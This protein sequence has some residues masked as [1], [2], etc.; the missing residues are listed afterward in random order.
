M[1]A[2]SRVRRGVVR[3]E[4][5]VSV[6]RRASEIVELLAE[7]SADGAVLTLASGR[8]VVLPA[9][10]LDVLRASARELASGHDVSVVPSDSMLTPAEAAGLLGLSRPFVVRLLDD[11]TIPSE[12]LTNSR[13]RRVLLADVLAFAARRERRRE[14]RRRVGARAAE[15]GIPY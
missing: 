11:G 7:P 10:L 4:A 12:R 1:V 2:R 3:V 8:T 9:R 6:V 14:G 5:D 15:A 13:H